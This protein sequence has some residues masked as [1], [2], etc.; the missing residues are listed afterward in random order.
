MNRK[1]SFLIS[2]L[3]AVFLAA[4]AAA[5][6][7]TVPVQ[8]VPEGSLAFTRE[9][10]LAKAEELFAG[11]GYTYAEGKYFRKAAGVQLPD[12]QAAWITFIERQD[13]DAAGN[14]YAVLSADTGEIIELYYPDNDVYTW[15]MLQWNDAKQQRRSDWPVEDQALFDWIFTDSGSMFDPSRAAVSSDEAV[16]IASEWVGGRFGMTYDDTHVSFMGHGDGGYSWVV[17]FL[18]NGSQV[19]NVYVS[20][21]TGE[22]EN[23]FDMAEGNG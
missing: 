4:G 8:Q 9:E 5:E 23:S 19:M 14:L 21:E 6:P 2:L 7:I 20:T 18:R 3:L 22:V 12:G 16:R 10:A 17:S 15:A 11:Q 13:A 1:L